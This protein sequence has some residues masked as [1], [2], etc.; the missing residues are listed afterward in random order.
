MRFNKSDPKVILDGV[1]ILLATMII[2]MTIF[3]VFDGSRMV[4]AITFYT[5]A[6]MFIINAVRGIM[7]KKYLALAALIP[8][9]L[10]IVGGL[11]AE[12]L[13]SLP[14]VIPS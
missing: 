4:L 9:A 7:S 2:G 12:G 11:M 3:V 13:I 1:I 6:L 8:C 5:G 14:G 10:C